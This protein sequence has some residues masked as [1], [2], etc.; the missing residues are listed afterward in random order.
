MQQSSSN[1]P[2]SGN[3]TGNIFR[4]LNIFHWRSRLGTRLA[5]F[6]TFA[7]LVPMAIVTWVSFIS[8]QTSLINQGAFKV[9]QETERIGQEVEVYLSQFPNDLLALSETFSVQ[10]IFRAQANDGIDPASLDSYDVW[11]SRFTQSLSS[12]QRNKLF[13]QQI[14]LLDEFGNEIVRT[15]FYDG[16][17]FIPWEEDLASQ[18]ESDYFIEAK[19][20]KKGEVYISSIEINQDYPDNNNL[21]VP[22]IRFSTPVFSVSD[23]FRGVLVSNLYASSIL[24]RLQTTSGETFLTDIQANY[25]FHPDPTK[26]LVAQ[27]GVESTAEDDFAGIFNTILEDEIAHAE[28]DP[29][30]ESFVALRHI[31]YDPTNDDSYW[32]LIRSLPQSEVIETATISQLL[33]SLLT[34]AVIVGFGALVLGIWLTRSIVNP[35]EAVSAAVARLTDRDANYEITLNP[36]SRDVANRS[37]ELG[38]LATSFNAMTVRLNELYTTL[39]DRVRNRTQDLEIAR[40]EADEA[41]TEAER[42][43]DLKTQFLSNMSHELRTPLN[44]IINMTGFVAEG[45][46]GEVNEEQI[47]ALN[48]TIDSGHHL[49]GLINDIL[50]LTKIEAGMMNVIFEDVDLDAVLQS[51]LSSATGLVANKPIKLISELQPGGLPSIV[52]DKRRIRQIFLNVISNA[53]KYTNEGTITLTAWEQNDS[54]CVSIKDTGI[55]IP[56]DDYSLVFQTFS[57]ARNS[58]DNVVSSGLGMPITKQLIELHGGEI[59]FESSV[60]IGST[61]YIQLPLIPPITKG[62]IVLNQDKSNNQK[63][64]M[65]VEVENNS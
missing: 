8:A 44:A 65:T 64:L 54:V 15:D 43:N 34:A 38:V 49:L 9:E 50:D 3:Q 24:E 18:S 27:D 61:F 1:Q 22:V 30:S 29:D 19:K 13:Y 26:A 28:L 12:V 46:M 58:L 41:R 51:V 2:V 47:S 4:N 39:E 53:V 16:R 59:W 5:T 23:D 20:L 56:E 33:Q 32:I 11:T 17:I 45:D 57:Q 37:D 14:R 25:L 40:R 36:I 21:K 55:G 63:D 60:D 52:G 62:T 10:A 31:H 7:A 6:V 48:I 35:V 42:A